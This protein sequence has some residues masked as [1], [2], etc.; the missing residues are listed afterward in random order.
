MREDPHIQVLE[1]TLWVLVYLYQMSFA[2]GGALAAVLVRRWHRDG[3][4]RWARIRRMVLWA[5]LAVLLIGG[6][7]LLI[8]PVI[9]LGMVKLMEITGADGNMGV[10]NEV[11][12]KIAV[13]VI[14]A[15]ATLAA[16]YIRDVSE[17]LRLKHSRGMTTVE[18][19]TAL[20]VLCGFASALGYSLYIVD[21]ASRL[22]ERYGL[23]GGIEPNPPARFESLS[24]LLWATDAA[25]RLATVVVMAAGVVLGA[26]IIRRASPELRDWLVLKGPRRI[27]PALA[28]GG[29]LLYAGQIETGRIG[30]AVGNMIEQVGLGAT[31]ASPFGVTFEALGG[32]TT[33][34]RIVL[35]VPLLPPVIAAW[36]LNRVGSA[37][38]ADGLGWRPSLVYRTVL[39][40]ALAWAVYWPV[41]AWFAV[42]PSQT[43]N[44][45]SRIATAAFL[46]GSVLAVLALPALSGAEQDEPPAVLNEGKETSGPPEP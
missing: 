18:S 25:T 41:E 22:I 3:L 40:L 2:I 45:S 21:G 27:V 46:A 20:I 26:Q 6:Q 4:V 32:N 7:Q 31:T 38:I 28:L 11:T 19:W 17:H 8:H 5:A 14:A 43:G 24:G 13:I 35:L 33:L 12:A 16:S 34:Y 39:V 36:L 23:V 1:R 42:G 37:A 29:L 9:W 10:A 15:T 44:D 30:G